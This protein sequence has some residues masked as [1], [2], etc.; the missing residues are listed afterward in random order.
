MFLQVLTICSHVLWFS[1][2]AHHILHHSNIFKHPFIVVAY[3]RGAIRGASHSNM[4]FGCPLHCWCRLRGQSQ[5]SLEPVWRG[6]AA[7]RVHDWM[8]S[9][10][11]LGRNAHLHTRKGCRLRAVATKKRCRLRWFC[12]SCPCFGHSIAG[13]V[14]KVANCQLKVAWW[15]KELATS[16]AA[17]C[18]QSK[19]CQASTAL[20]IH[21]AA[22]TFLSGRLNFL[23][24]KIVI[25]VSVPW[26][27]FKL[28][29]ERISLDLITTLLRISFWNWSC[30]EVVAFKFEVYWLDWWIGCSIEKHFVGG[31]K[32]ENMGMVQWLLLTVSASLK[33]LP[34]WQL[35][36]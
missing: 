32:L 7:M 27:V 22:N 30:F 5:T 13:C 15:L 35:S 31:W 20:Q 2:V 29:P 18:L 28:L 6:A 25:F 3:P 14:S 26:F 9:R 16:A 17:H 23:C 10:C 36:F 1:M 8:A 4:E 33:V 21:T 11:L 34:L 12:V 19:Q 24:S